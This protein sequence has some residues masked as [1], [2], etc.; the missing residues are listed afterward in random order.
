MGRNQ[1]RHDE[2][3]ELAGLQAEVE[4]LAAMVRTTNGATVQE[5]RANLQQM[6]QQ[7]AAL[8]ACLARLR[9]EMK[10]IKP[11]LQLARSQRKMTAEID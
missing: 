6:Q 2:R 11:P 5:Q 1:N 9:V 4:R 7:M 3:S 8:E 10:A